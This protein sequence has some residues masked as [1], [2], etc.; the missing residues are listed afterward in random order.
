MYEISPEHNWIKRMINHLNSIIRTNLGIQ[1]QS[2]FYFDEQLQSTGMVTRDRKKSSTQYV[3]K[4]AK[5][6]QKSQ[7]VLL[8]N[9][10]MTTEQD[11]RISNNSKRELSK[12]NILHSYLSNRNYKGGNFG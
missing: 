1:Y 9:Y 5:K 12:L 7:S 2:S 4:K 8:D 11:L 6:L 3:P 10:T